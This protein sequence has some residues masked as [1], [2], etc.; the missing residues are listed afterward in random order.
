MRDPE[1]RQDVPLHVAVQDLQWKARG[2]D[3]DEEEK[4]GRVN[5]PTAGHCTAPTS[6]LRHA[7]LHFTVHW[8]GKLH[9]IDTDPLCIKYGQ[10]VTIYSTFFFSL[11][12]SIFKHCFGLIQRDELC[13][14]TILFWCGRV[15]AGMCASRSPGSLNKFPILSVTHGKATLR[16]CN[17]VSLKKK[18]GGT[19][20][21]W[22]KKKINAQSQDCPQG[23]RNYENQPLKDAQ[24]VHQCTNTFSESALT[25]ES[26]ITLAA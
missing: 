10:Q 9:S 26:V 22:K 16:R 11:S 23:A 4:S 8:R 2:E 3:E 5:S 12:V 19:Y 13:R 6:R 18:R 7:E 25:C 15:F 24:T 21:P 14:N 20:R 1:R 17:C